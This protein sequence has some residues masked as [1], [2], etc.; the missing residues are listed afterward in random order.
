MD[1]EIENSIYIIAN[2]PM[3]LDL[4]SNPKENYTEIKR[5][6]ME[7]VKKNVY[8]PTK[9][10]MEL[11]VESLNYFV[12]GINSTLKSDSFHYLVAYSEE[13]TV[14]DNCLFSFPKDQDIRK[15]SVNYQGPQG[16]K[17]VYRAIANNIIGAMEKEFD[18][19]QVILDSIHSLIEDLFET[20]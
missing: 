8:V 10:V 1:M 3:F 11:F 17:V 5:V 18:W 14:F 9:D 4:L 2:I 15:F 19:L 6:G 16:K 12:K 7:L 20:K 13:C